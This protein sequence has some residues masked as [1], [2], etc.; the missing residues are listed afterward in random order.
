M[1]ELF[2]NV[3]VDREERPDVDAVYMDA[4][5]GADRPGRLAAHGLPHARRRAVLRRHL[6]P[7][8]AAARAALVPAG[9]ARDRRRVPRAAART[10]PR[11]RTRSSARCGDRP[12]PSRRA[13]RST[14]GAARRGRARAARRSSTHAGAASG[15]R[16]SSRLRRRSSSSCAAASLE[17]VRAHARRDGGGRDVRPASAAASTA[18]R[19]DAEW[20]V[21]HFEKMLYDNALLVPPYLHAWVLTGE[22]RYREVS[23]RTLDYMLRELR[24]PGGGFASSQDA[25]TDG[26]EGLTYTWT[27]EEARRRSCCSRSSTAARSCAASST[28]RRGAAARDPR[29]APAAGARRQGRSPR[30]TGWCSRP[31]RRAPAGSRVPLCYR[32]RCEL[33]E[34]LLCPTAAGCT[35]R[36]GRAKDTALSRGLR[37]RRARPLRA[38]RR[39]RRAALAAGGAAARARRGG[40]VR[41]PRARRLLP[42]AG[43]R[44]AARRA[45]EGP[46]RQPDP[47]RKLDARLCAPAPRADLGRRR[48]RAAGGRRAAPRARRDPPGASGVRLGA[49]R[50][51]PP[52]VAAARAAIVGGPAARSPGP[53]SR[54]LDPN[55]VVAF[56][57]A[58][59]VRCSRARPRRRQAGRLR[60]RALRLPGAGHRRRAS[61]AETTRGSLNCPRDCGCG[62]ALVPAV[63]DLAEGCK[64]PA[65]AAVATSSRSAAPSGRR[66]SWRS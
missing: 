51:R 14:D 1:N 8:G 57:P 4:V 19:V 46:R 49:L 21:P 29:P 62:T 58:D 60:L 45:P 36:N 64:S 34:L 56:G 2:V 10:S 9:A 18:T 13:S 47:V 16:R 55:T 43:R 59:D 66:A 39:H 30:G 31:S 52:P 42:H 37:E 20:L 17:P 11:R 6:L 27:A 7:A 35:L 12:R 26:I 50:A 38:A 61:S 53:R 3:K 28:R 65:A 25:D 44:R 54:G 24:L 40:A 32:R 33:G 63:E 5:V 48:A 22:E 41:R 15:T 23:E